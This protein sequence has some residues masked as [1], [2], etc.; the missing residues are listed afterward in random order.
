MSTD[1][2]CRLFLLDWIRSKV[3]SPYPKKNHLHDLAKQVC[4]ETTHHSSDTIMLHYIVRWFAIRSYFHCLSRVGLGLWNLFN[5]WLVK[6]VRLFVR[7]F[8]PLCH[9]ANPYMRVCVW[10]EWFICSKCSI[11]LRKVLSSNG[12]TIDTWVKYLKTLEPF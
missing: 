7:C 6:I 1:Y 3:Q 5:F 8:S 11:H 2:N 12:G 9:C 4:C 10:P